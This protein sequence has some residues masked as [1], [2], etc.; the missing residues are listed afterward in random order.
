VSTTSSGS[1]IRWNLYLISDRVYDLRHSTAE[2]TSSIL[3]TIPGPQGL[4]QS[5]LAILSIRAHSNRCQRSCRLEVMGTQMKCQLHLN[6]TV[7]P[8]YDTSLPF[9]QQP[10]V[11]TQPNSVTEVIPTH[12]VICIHFSLEHA[13][14]TLV[15]TRAQFTTSTVQTKLH[16][17]CIAKAN[18]HEYQAIA[19]KARHE[20]NKNREFQSIQAIFHS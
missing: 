18:V 4:S 8:A 5:V 6:C 7:L 16:E 11:D 20:V 12:L 1:A 2:H 17:G 13:C 15:S 19:C 14:S 9:F 3:A 10:I